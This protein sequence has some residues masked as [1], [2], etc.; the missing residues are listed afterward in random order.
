MNRKT[1]VVLICITVITNAFFILVPAIVRA[2]EYNTDRPGMDYYSFALPIDNYS[3]CR[4]QCLNDPN[5]RAWTYVRPGIQ[6]PNARCWLKNGVPPPYRNSCCIS[7]VKRRI[8]QSSIEYNTV[9]P[10]MDYRNFDLPTADHMICRDICMNDPNC[11]AWTY[12]RP[13]IQGPNARCWLKNNVP[14]Q[15]NNPCC[16]SGIVR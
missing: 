1:L 6:G 10:G 14:P 2:I 5:C 16:I 4:Q 11:R 9:R 13:G 15:N 7:E 3:I 12:V 8:T